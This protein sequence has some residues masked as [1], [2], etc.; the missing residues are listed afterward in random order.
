MGRF[1]ECSFL[2][3][4]VIESVLDSARVVAR[5]AT[6]P[7][8]KHAEIVDGPCE[9]AA[10]ARSMAEPLIQAETARAGRPRPRSS[11]RIETTS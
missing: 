2:V 6:V 7:D 9:V 8:V 5:A 4:D 11:F 1:I 10:A 3:V